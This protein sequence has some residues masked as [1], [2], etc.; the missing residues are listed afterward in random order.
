M[1]V[2]SRLRDFERVQ[3][4]DAREVRVM[5]LGPSRSAVSGVSTHLNQLMG[6]PLAGQFRFDH[7]QVGSEGRSEG[8]IDKA[9]RLTFSPLL[10][11]YR[12]LS[13][14]SAIVHINSSLDQ[15][16]FWRD[17]AY[18]L[19]AKVVRCKIVY[20]VHGGELPD[21][22]FG[23]R[24]PLTAFLKWMLRL[25][26][27]IVLLAEVERSA[28]RTFGAFRNLSVIPNAIDSDAYAP[29]ARG[30]QFGS[31]LNIAYIGRLVYD[32]GIFE[33][34]EA[35]RILR[36]S[37]INNLTLSIAGS[38]PAENELK[39]QTRALQLEHDVRFVGPVHGE[40]KIRFWRNADLFVFPTFHREG[41]PYALL[42]SLASGTPVITTAV[43]AIPDV[44]ADGV[45]G[46][47]VNPHAAAEVANAVRRLILDRSLMQRMSRA[48][49]ERAREGYGVERLSDDFAKLYTRVLA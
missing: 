4:T 26:D 16:A 10:L 37:G 7:F 18:L 31:A 43:G 21:Q 42:E 23:G 35:L 48:C 22:F 12:L 1:R 33:A 19:I 25:P 20:Q 29:E 17:T 44:V 36:D 49:L 14:G 2:I 45:H 5:L 32:K 30:R 40:Q 39:E 13:R 41:L 8:S 46:I 47:M 9:M 15:K 11:G 28:Y 34:I 27:A 24:Q 6:S 3:V 38:G